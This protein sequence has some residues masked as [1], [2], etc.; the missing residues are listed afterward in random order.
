MLRRLHNVKSS[1]NLRGILWM[2]RLLNVFGENLMA[3][4][5]CEVFEL[6]YQRD[7]AISFSS[8]GNAVVRREVWNSD[9]TAGT[10][11][12]LHSIRSAYVDCRSDRFG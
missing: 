11:L 7:A 12:A 8:R 5:A 9:S 1:C 10:R 2:L 6:G 4:L 3:V